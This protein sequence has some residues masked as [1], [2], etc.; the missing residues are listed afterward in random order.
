M[1]SANIYSQSALILC[2]P[3]CNSVYYKR[4]MTRER[5]PQTQLGAFMQMKQKKRGMVQCLTGWEKKTTRTRKSKT[6][7]WTSSS[8]QDPKKE[9]NHEHAKHLGHEPAIARHAVPVLEQ[10]PLCAFDVLLE[11]CL[12]VTVFES[13]MCAKGLPRLRRLCLHLYVVSAPLVR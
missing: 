8:Y 13:G 2:A 7:V 6:C 4:S 11:D 5:T 10:F 1:F 9:E 3:I 12:L